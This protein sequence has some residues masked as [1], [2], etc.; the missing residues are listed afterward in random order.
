MQHALKNAAIY[1][2]TYVYVGKISNRI[3][4]RGKGT[5]PNG[6]DVALTL[7]TQLREIWRY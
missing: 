4:V 6:C 2:P 3:Q 5:E 7:K 1:R